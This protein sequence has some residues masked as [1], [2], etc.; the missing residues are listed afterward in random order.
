MR[1]LNR[2]QRGN[3]N[4]LGSSGPVPIVQDTQGI[5]LPLQTTMPTSEEDII[6]HEEDE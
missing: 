4:T 2:I 6:L 1:R 5:T 3:N